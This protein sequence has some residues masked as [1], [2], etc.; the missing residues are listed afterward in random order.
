MS[1]GRTPLA[2]DPALVELLVAN[3]V[4]NALR[5]NVTGGKIHVLTAAAPEGGILTVSNT[6]PLVPESAIPRL[7]QPFQAA[8]ADRTRQRADGHELGLAIVRAAAD[9]H[10]A[11]IAATPRPDGGLE[12]TITFPSSESAAARYLAD[13]S[14]EV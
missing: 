6:G 8:G 9:A 14:D 11:A 4:E 5:H 3:L 10:G 12:I 1:L 7:F 13:P 2:G